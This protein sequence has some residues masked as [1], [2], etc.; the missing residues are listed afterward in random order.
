MLLL[1]LP[2]K[3]G[4]KKI[5]T[6]TAKIPVVVSDGSLVTELEV[7]KQEQTQQI[8]IPIDTNV[9]IKKTKIK[10]PIAAETLVVTDIEIYEEP[11]HGEQN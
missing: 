7:P 11:P 9:V 5:K 8:N 6:R 1:L 4:V 2:P 10:A 3:N